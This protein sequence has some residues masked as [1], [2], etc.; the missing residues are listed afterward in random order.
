LIR[1]PGT[2]GCGTRVHL[3]GAMAI[4]MAA[5]RSTTGSSSVASSSDPRARE[6]KGVRRLGQPG[7]CSRL[8]D[9]T[10]RDPLTYELA[11]PRKCD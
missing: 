2:G 11:F 5:T 10:A 4:S 8:H 9:V 7:S 1:R 6:T 3:P